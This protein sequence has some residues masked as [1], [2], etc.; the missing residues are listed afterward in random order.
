[1]PTGVHLRDARQQLLD[2]AERVLLRDGA[3]G[4]TSRAVT[5]EAGCAKGVL[6]RHFSDFDDLLTAL[7]LD[8]ASRLDAEMATLRASVGT[9][10]VVDNLTI[11]LDALLGPVPTAIIP[12]ITFRDV[13][14][15]RLR[16]ATP[17]GGMAILAHATT[18]IRDYLAAERSRG[19]LRAGADLDALALSLVGGGHLMAADTIAP[20]SRDAVRRFVAGA[21][22]RN[23]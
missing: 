17:G 21:L 6:H 19:R 10:A 23:I 2:A 5:E 20:P 3:A 18:G 14:R 12:L 13:L 22:T 16:E 1:M 8:C 7:V 9:G 11:A 4:L 15:T